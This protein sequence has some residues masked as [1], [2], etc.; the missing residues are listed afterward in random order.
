MEVSEIGLGCNNF[1]NRVDLE[2]TRAVV[3]K[4]L[5]LGVTFF[6][7]VAGLKK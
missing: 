6:G 2:G 1:G 7:G 5:D 3:S 4:A